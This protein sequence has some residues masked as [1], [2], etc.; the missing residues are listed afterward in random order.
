MIFC[1]SDWSS[2]RFAVACPRARATVCSASYCARLTFC[3]SRSAFCVA[4]CFSTIACLN[5]ASLKN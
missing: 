5:A 3:C 1:V 2:S 4:T